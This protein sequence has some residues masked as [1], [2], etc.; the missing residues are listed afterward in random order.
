[1]YLAYFYNRGGIIVDGWYGRLTV[2]CDEKGRLTLEDD[3]ELVS[4]EQWAAIGFWEIGKE[5]F[6]VW[7]KAA[8]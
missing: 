7:K 1:M 4:R 3:Y 8:A 2:P 6:D 5:P